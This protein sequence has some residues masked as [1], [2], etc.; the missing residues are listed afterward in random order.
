LQA[1]WLSS[2]II[3][4]RPRGEP[5]GRGRRSSAEAWCHDFNKT[6]SAN[7]SDRFPI[8]SCTMLSLFNIVL[9]AGSSS[10]SAFAAPDMTKVNDFN[11]VIATVRSRTLV[12]KYSTCW[13]ARTQYSRLIRQRASLCN[14]SIVGHKISVRFNDI[15]V[16]PNSHLDV[17]LFM[18]WVHIQSELDSS[19]RQQFPLSRNITQHSTPGQSV[20]FTH[21]L[22]PSFDFSISGTE[23]YA[24]SL[25]RLG[26]AWC[27]V[28][29]GFTRYTVQTGSSLTISVN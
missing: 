2:E 15:S 20:E 28:T 13:T 3:G 18:S 10:A 19:T 11:I 25:T 7:D 1:A 29:D 14:V 21:T 27:H 26:K 4:A 23:E 6:L 16:C 17:Y 12:A 8:A 24:V 22:L 9:A 5:S